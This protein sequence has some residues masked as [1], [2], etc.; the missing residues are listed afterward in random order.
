MQSTPRPIRGTARP[1]RSSIVHGFVLTWVKSRRDLMEG[2]RGSGE[3]AVHSR[4]DLTQLVPAQDGGVAVKAQR[5]LT[6]SALRAVCRPS[7]V[8][9]GAEL[10]GDTAFLRSSFSFHWR[11]FFYDDRSFRQ[12]SLEVRFRRRCYW[13]HFWLLR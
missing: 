13:W 1:A 11:R 9:A 8:T 10:A 6:L 12:R 4:R 2:T 5:A 3:E 7:A